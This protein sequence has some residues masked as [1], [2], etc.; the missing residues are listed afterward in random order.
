MNHDEDE[1]VNDTARRAGIDAVRR[2]HDEARKFGGPISGKNGGS[3]ELG[4]GIPDRF[5]RAIGGPK[6]P[7]VIKLDGARGKPIEPLEL[8]KANS[9]EG[10][11]VPERAW[12][13]EGRIPAGNVSLL[14]GDG[15][16][17]K[18]L[19]ALMLS[20]AVARG[21]RWLDASFLP[22]K[23]TGTNFIDDLRRLSHTMAFDLPTCRTCISIAARVK[24]GP[25][26]ELHGPEPS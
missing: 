11:S 1:D 23:K 9:F 20:V 2:R 22:L 12:L 26:A 15:A 4:N 24:M 3:P 6:D 17:G 14:G 10:L 7:I 8:L 16:V 19:L 5:E 25:W 18:T 21:T 13:V